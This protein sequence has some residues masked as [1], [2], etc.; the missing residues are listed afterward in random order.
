MKIKIV[1]HAITTSGSFNVGQ[2]LT[3]KDFTDV[4]LQHLVDAKAA[5]IMEEIETK[6]EPDK[7]ETKP[8]TNPI[9]KKG[10]KGQKKF[11]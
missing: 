7:I 3:S 6:P 10:K 9:L 2:I 1:N 11:S 8:D 4:F 5:I